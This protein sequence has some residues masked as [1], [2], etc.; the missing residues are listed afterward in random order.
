MSKCSNN[1]SRAISVAQFIC[2]DN[3]HTMTEAAEEFGVSR[4][5]I[6]RDLTYL[7][8]LADCDF[9]PNSAKVKA[10]YLKARKVINHHGKL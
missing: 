2:E 5:T 10:I 9:N 8:T 4:T 1:L 6:G 7:A 3:G